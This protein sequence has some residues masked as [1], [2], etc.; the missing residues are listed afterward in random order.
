MFVRDHVTNKYPNTS[1]IVRSLILLP[2]TLDSV[3][4]SSVERD[5]QR[6]NAYATI[7]EINA[8]MMKGSGFLDVESDLKRY[9]NLHID[10]PSP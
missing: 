8:F 6:R 3:I 10:F 2:E 4:D 7:K 9:G 5:S 1:L